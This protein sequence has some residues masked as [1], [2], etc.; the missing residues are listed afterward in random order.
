VGTV[1][2]NCS[3]FFILHNTAW[4]HQA[5]ELWLH[6]AKPTKKFRAPHPFKLEQKV[7]ELFPCAKPPKSATAIFSS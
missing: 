7:A 2:S 6:V 4:L 1:Y 5:A 3:V